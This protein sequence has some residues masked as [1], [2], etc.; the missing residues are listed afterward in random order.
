MPSDMETV[1][2]LSSQFTSVWN[3]SAIAL[4]GTSVLL[5]TMQA[6]VSSVTTL[7][8][9]LIL[10]LSI[11]RLTV[12][13]PFVDVTVLVFWSHSTV[14]PRVSK[15]FLIGTIVL[16]FIICGDT[17]KATAWPSI[18]TVIPLSAKQVLPKDIKHK[19]IVSVTVNIFFILSSSFLFNRI[20]I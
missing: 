17:S 10:G 6:G 4:T 1:F 13:P 7:P 9:T 5:S 15:I 14:A 11:V 3:A 19:K 18:F 16:L 2:V 20:L 8:F 12:V